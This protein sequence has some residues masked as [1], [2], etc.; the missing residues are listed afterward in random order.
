MTKTTIVNR[1]EDSSY[2]GGA[3]KLVGC[4]A[5]SA[6]DLNYPVEITLKSAKGNG[7]TLTYSVDAYAYSKKNEGGALENLV[8]S[9]MKYIRSASRYA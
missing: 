6:R 2:S 3:C 7:K 8:E 9:I 4:N 5:L 1:F